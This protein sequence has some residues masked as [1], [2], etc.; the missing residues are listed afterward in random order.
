MALAASARKH[1]IDQETGMTPTETSNSP[2]RS[3]RRGETTTVHQQ[4]DY[5]E[6]RTAE[7]GAADPT[8]EPQLPHEID[9]SSHSQASASAQ[10]HDVGKQA[11]ADE[12]GPSTDTDRG[13]VL[14]E[15]YNRTLAPDR[16]EDEP[17]Q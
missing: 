14:D 12:T 7:Q 16:G 1:S 3:P 11:Y 5:P 2:E 13:P 15:V 4:S 10:H 8:V 17:R 9:E 6:A